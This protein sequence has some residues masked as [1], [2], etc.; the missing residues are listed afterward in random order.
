[1]KLDA[2]PRLGDETVDSDGDGIPD[3]L[4][5]STP[6]LL[7][8]PGTDRYVTAWNFRSIPSLKDSDGDGYE[9]GYDPMPLR[10][11]IAIQELYGNVI[12]LNT[13][14]TYCV[15]GQDIREFYY[16]YYTRAGNPGTGEILESMKSS[17]D[18]NR[19]RQYT[20]DEMAF[21]C[22][23]DLNGVKDYVSGQST[24]YKK[25]VFFKCTGQEISDEI[26]EEFF[27]I[28]Y[29]DE[30]WDLYYRDASE[31]I[32]LGEYTEKGNLVGSMGELGLAFTGADV[33]QDLR[34]LSYN[35]THWEEDWQGNLKNTG[36]IILG[37]ISL[38]PVIGIVGKADEFIAVLKRG[39]NLFELRKLR[40]VADLLRD[41]GNTKYM[42]K[43]RQLAGTAME[44]LQSMN[45]AVYRKILNY[46]DN[47][48]SYRTA[49]ATAGSYSNP[50][51][52]TLSKHTDELDDLS[53]VSSSL[54]REVV[55]EV[56]KAGS[57][58][59]DNL[60]DIAREALDNARKRADEIVEGGNNLGKM[61]LD[62][63][64]Q[65]VQDAFKKYDDAG[66]QGNV[67]GQT[68]GTNAGR[69][70]GNR[71]GQLP[72]VDTNGTPITYRE[73]DVNNYNGVSRD[74]ERFI[75]GSDGSVWYTDSHYGQGD[76]LN[77]I[78][79]FVQIK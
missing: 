9:D 70:W 57:R 19:Q 24:A 72:T 15:F 33:V 16:Q 28:P 14:S 41:L 50:V 75:V 47:A 25:E 60:D 69:K 5:L 76:S 42:M 11:N 39:E 63:L 78:A 44:K 74:G 56:T 51:I 64:P 12:K 54:T 62:N 18:I 61:D 10:F 2:D 22:N 37:G 7:N 68:Q 1:M 20:T 45:P 21:L 59:A 46:C 40:H 4:E 27:R 17:L 52:D 43:T 13:G 48:P 58:S 31:Q 67:S 53:K 66:W 79:D 77:G 36:E 35:I 71:D 34:D 3:L 32:V 65:N 38:I 29:T 30:A 26:A 8:I 49:Y 73:F 23:I 55:E 6:T